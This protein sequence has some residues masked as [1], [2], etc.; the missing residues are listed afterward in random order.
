MRLGVLLFKILRRLSIKVKLTSEEYLND[1][2]KKGVSVGGGTYVHD[3]NDVLIDV[4]HP[5]LLTIGE[6]VFIHKGA[7]ILTHDWTGWCIVNT[8][9]EFIPSHNRVS[10]GNNVWMGMRVMILKGVTIGD[11]VIIGAGSVVTKSIPS[12]SVAVGVPARV[13]CSYQDYVERRFHDHIGEAKELAEAIIE[14]GRRPIA[15]DLKDDY[16]CFVDGSNYTDYDYPYSRI[17]TH[18][19]FEMWKVNHKKKYEDFNSF[20]S[21]VQK[22]I[23]RKKNESNCNK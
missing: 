3:T 6:N 23:N 21:Y 20:M 10:I 17:F 14:K 13:I 5:E 9:N 22:E 18:E 15:D 12:N 4:S 1:I 19:Q 7:I 16:S 2:R 8:H 11:N